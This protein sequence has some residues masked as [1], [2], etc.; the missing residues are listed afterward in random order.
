MKA[1]LRKGSEMENRFN[2]EGHWK[3]IK[4]PFFHSDNINS[5]S[6]EGIN[7]NT[8]IRQVFRTKAA[9]FNWEKKYCM[10]IHECKQCGIYSLAN[11]KYGVN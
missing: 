10:K 9:R 2:I 5:I 11:E 7:E 3:Q 1:N 6:C 4:C 8:S